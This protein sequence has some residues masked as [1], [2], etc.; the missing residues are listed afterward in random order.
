MHIV[1]KRV[2][3]ETPVAPKGR[4]TYKRINYHQVL[5][6]KPWSMVVADGDTVAPASPRYDE[7][8]TCPDCLLKMGMDIYR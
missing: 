7:D 1:H 4:K 2:V 5:C 6:L 8:V 3:T